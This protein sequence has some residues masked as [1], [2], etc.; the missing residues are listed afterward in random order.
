MADR[1]QELLRILR[2]PTADTAS[3]VAAARE[4]LNRGW[5][6]PTEIVKG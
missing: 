5:P 2:D 6:A 4:I 3:R 1:L